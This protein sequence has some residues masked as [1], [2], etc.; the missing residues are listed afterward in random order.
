MRKKNHAR[1]GSE[2][3]ASLIYRCPSIDVT[4]YELAPICRW[5]VYEIILYKIRL[6]VPSSNKA[7]L[8]FSRFYWFRVPM[9]T[10]SEK[11]FYRFRHNMK[12]LYDLVN[13]QHAR[14]VLYF[15]KKRY[16]SLSCGWGN[17]GRPWRFTAAIVS[18]FR[19]W[20]DTGF[21]FLRFE[22]SGDSCCLFSE[23]TSFLM[24]LLYFV[25]ISDDVDYI[26]S[27]KKKPKK[28]HYFLCRTPRHVKS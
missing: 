22:F 21:T 28:L 16:V 27:K 23:W 9:E 8:N 20:V 4:F 5:Q 26:F 19:I 7:T 14:D 24:R 1:N 12:M 25:A 10:A 17:L 6:N 18:G 15:R 13:W 11:L 3:T 2:P